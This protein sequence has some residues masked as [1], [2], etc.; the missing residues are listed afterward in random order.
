MKNRRKAMTN[1]RNNMCKGPGA[2]GG[3]ASGSEGI[4]GLVDWTTQSEGRRDGKVGSGWPW[5]V[6]QPAEEWGADGD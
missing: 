4:R 5:R 1:R 3:R 6:L 2:S